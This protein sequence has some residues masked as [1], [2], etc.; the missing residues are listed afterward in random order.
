MPTGLSASTRSHT[1]RNVA[2]S[3]TARN[4]PGTP[5]IQDQKTSPTKTASGL[6]AKLR[7]ST[8]GVTKLATKPTIARNTPGTGA[9]RLG[10]SNVVNPTSVSTP[11]STVAPT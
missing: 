2:S 7:P 9:I 6:S 3:G 8:C 5:Q 1:M 11:A 10:E 4:V